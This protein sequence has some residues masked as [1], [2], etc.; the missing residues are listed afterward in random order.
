M[1][2]AGRKSGI[3]SL[4]RR[5]PYSQE[6]ANTLY[7][8]HMGITGLD[9]DSARFIFFIKGGKGGG[10]YI[11][12]FHKERALRFTVEHHA[13]FPVRGSPRRRPARTRPFQ[14]DCP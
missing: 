10:G 6:P 9:F 3:A 4:E 1:G 11:N 14:A 13:Y 5:V 12:R 7:T 8:R 2:G